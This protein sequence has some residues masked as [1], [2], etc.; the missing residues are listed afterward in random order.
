[1]KC[2]DEKNTERY[3]TLIQKLPEDY[4]FEYHRLIQYGLYFIIGMNFAKRGREGKILTHS[5]FFW[6]DSKVGKLI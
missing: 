4:R 5:K 2:G 6:L 1:M 3:K